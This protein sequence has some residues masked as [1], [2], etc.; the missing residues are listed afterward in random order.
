MF[1]FFRKTIF[2]TQ[3]NLNVCNS[4]LS[5]SKR[6]KREHTQNLSSCNRNVCGDTFY[7]IIIND[8]RHAAHR[9]VNMG[10][11]IIYFP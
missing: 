10:R 6:V 7:S 3:K 9:Y 2:M 8:T 11:E 1:Y 4:A 5:K